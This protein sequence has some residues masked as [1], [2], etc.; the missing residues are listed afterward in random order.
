MGKAPDAFRTISEVADWLGVQTHVL[1]FWESKFTQVKPLKR[2]GGR[3]YYRPADMELLGGIRKLLHEDGLTIKG[4][5]KFIRENGVKAVAELSPPV[6]DE[7]DLPAGVPTEAAAAMMPEAEAEVHVHAVETQD[8]PEAPVD[9]TGEAPAPAVEPEP[10]GYFDAVDVTGEDAAPAVQPEPEGYFDAVDVSAEETAPAA[11]PEISETVDVTG[12]APAPAAEP[13]PEGYFDA[14]DVTGEEPA[15]AAEP[16]SEAAEVANLFDDEPEDPAD[17][18]ST[19][20]AESDEDEELALPSFIR[21]PMDGQETTVPPLTPGPLPLGE[22]D[23]V[24]EAAPEEIDSRFAGVGAGEV[25]DRAPKPEAEEPANAPVDF[26]AAVAP[27]PEMPL[28]QQI[29]A[30]DEAALDAAALRPLYD[31]LLALRARMG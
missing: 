15:P 30:S 31:R 22:E 10:E 18:V 14:V 11:E 20:A 6:E 25:P 13:E 5:Q 12:E 23:R 7:G 19:P 8:T 24:G 9:V 1:R 28:P 21:K 17:D 29:T 2:A 3:R 26:V 16:E 4:A 27:D